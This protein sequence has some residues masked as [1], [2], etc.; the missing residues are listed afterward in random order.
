MALKA[1]SAEFW[2]SNRAVGLTKKK[3]KTPLLKSKHE[4]SLKL[5]GSEQKQSFKWNLGETH[6]QSCEAFWRGT[7]Q[8][9][10]TL[11]TWTL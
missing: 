10:L 2:E 11:G 7:R 8:I 5:Y 9:E 6:L 4:I 3:K 1:S